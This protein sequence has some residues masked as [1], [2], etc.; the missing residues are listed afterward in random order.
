[1]DNISYSDSN[2]LVCQQKSRSSHLSW[3]RVIPKWI[4]LWVSIFELFLSVWNTFGYFLHPQYQLNWPKEP[5][6][7][8][9]NTGL[10]EKLNPAFVKYKHSPLVVLKQHSQVTQPLFVGNKAD[11]CLEQCLF[12]AKMVKTGYEEMYDQPSIETSHLSP[13]WVLIESIIGIMP[14]S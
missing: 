1:M 2:L 7:S 3:T 11:V 9:L 4:P 10:H 6:W 12:P 8:L 5:L 14:I 13:S